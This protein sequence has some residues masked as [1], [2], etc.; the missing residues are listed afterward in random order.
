MV[1]TTAHVQRDLEV[2][3]LADGAAALLRD[4]ALHLELH[5]LANSLCTGE[6]GV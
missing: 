2:D 6:D 5:T 4:P 3:K 1:A